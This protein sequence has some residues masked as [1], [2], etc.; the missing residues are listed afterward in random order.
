MRCSAPSPLGDP[1]WLGL[2]APPSSSKTEILNSISTLPYV[3]QAATV[4]PAALPSGFPRK[5]I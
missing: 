2:V 4:T 3:Y 5:Q 1:V